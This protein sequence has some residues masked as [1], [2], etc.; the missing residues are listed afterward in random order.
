M[1]FDIEDQSKKKQLKKKNQKKTI[2]L[3]IF[4]IFISISF[5]V[6]TYMIL[7]IDNKPIVNQVETEPI[8]EPSKINIVDENSNERPI[9]VMID[10]NIGNIK[11]AGLQDSYVNYEIIVEGGL[12]RIMAIYKDKEISLIGP[13]RSSR[14]YFLDY[15]LEHDAIYTHYGWSPYAEKDIKNLNVQ[16]INGMTDAEPFARDTNLPS[17]HNVFTSIPK[18]RSY[19]EK[20]NY[21]ETS[22]SWKVFEYSTEEVEFKEEEALS[23]N[24]VSMYYSYSENRSYTYDYENKYYL[25]FNNGQMHLD[26]E[27]NQQLHYKNIIIMKV[28]NKTLDSEGRQDLETTGAGTGYYITNGFAK[29]IKWYKSSRISK[30]NYT[31]IDG[32]EVVLN[33]GNT[34]IQIVPISSTIEIE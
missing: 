11:H 29:E 1:N 31:Y 24:K 15:A 27:S 9:A 13:V 30:T 21:S 28:E 2:Y 23:A 4:I 5:M 8:I 14:H 20:K 12:T 33:D 32:T 10:N 7:N 16:N 19:S 22:S 18:I 25:R 34:F 26:R 6:I 3:F 17:P